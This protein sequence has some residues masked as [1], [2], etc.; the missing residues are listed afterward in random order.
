VSAAV[1]YESSTTYVLR[2]LR[3]SSDEQADKGLS[4]PFQDDE[5][6]RYVL[7]R[8][9]D[10]WVEDGRYVDVLSGKRDER[11]DYQRLLAR[12]RELRKQRQ[13]VVVVVFRCDRFG[14][15][16]SERSTRWEELVGLDIELHSVYEGGKQERTGHNIRAFLA[17]EEV[18]ALAERV[19][20]ARRYVVQRG[21]RPVG[22]CPWGYRWRPATDD[23]RGRGAPTKVLD[24]DESSAMY[25]RL[26]WRMRADGKSL[27]DISR[28]AADLPTEE[29]GG[30]TL[31]YSAIRDM[32]KAPV[33]AARPDDGADDVL[34]RPIGNWPPLVDDEMWAAVQAMG[35]Q[36][37]RVPSQA[38]GRY[39]LTGLLRCWRCTHR[40]TGRRFLPKASRERGTGRYRSSYRCIAH[41]RGARGG[42]AVCLGE[43]PGATVER[44]VLER[45]ERLL[46]DVT[47][48]DVLALFEEQQRRAARDE[49]ANVGGVA[50]RLGKETARI[51]EQ[52]Q[53]LKEAAGYLGDGVMGPADYKIVREET[54]AEIAA[55]ERA[56]AE[57]KGGRSHEQPVALAVLVERARDWSDALRKAEDVA[58]ARMALGQ[59]I[60]MV[61]PVPEGGRW[62]R[63]WRVEIAWRPIMQQIV[64]LSE[65]RPVRG[66]DNSNPQTA[67]SF[68]HPDDHELAA[69]A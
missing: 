23:E 60:E 55:A 34:A 47:D 22:R 69:S 31:D 17:E 4:I 27:T 32:L 2:Y 1:R 19:T 12:A 58:A 46:G 52:R 13:R 59:M 35:D 29:R 5:T 61:V 15:R 14:R 18:A 8:A 56:I 39:L 57:L 68:S 48:P 63:Q 51:K 64:A 7:A 38:S 36:R 37:R 44:L 6:T 26:A 66:L 49:S 10:G 25:V 43:A 40:M 21:W 33:Y 62:S 16:L 24:V 50:A 28:H 54:L 20:A 65:E 30:R 45:I 3:V 42:S 9:A 41:M 11:V 53:R 67:C